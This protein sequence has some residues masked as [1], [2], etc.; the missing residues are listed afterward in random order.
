MNAYARRTRRSRLTYVGIWAGGT[1][2][3]VALALAGYPA[4]AGGVFLLAGALAVGYQRRT[5]A[6]FDERDDDILR[7]ASANTMATVGLAAALFFPGMAVL[8][9]LDV[10]AW[11]EW[12]TPVALFVAAL[13]ALWG[14]QV[15]LARARR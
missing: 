8:A 3:Y 10:V 14:L 7:T 12:L 9:G 13:Y 2:A 6:L 1:V 5:D 15:A 4:V 11:P